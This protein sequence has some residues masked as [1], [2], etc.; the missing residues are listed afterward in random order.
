MVSGMRTGQAKCL[1]LSWRS[2][3]ARNAPDTPYDWNL[4]QC[5][6]TLRQHRAHFMNN[7]VRP[8]ERGLQLSVAAPR[9]ARSDSAG[10]AR[11]EADKWKMKFARKAA[12]L[13]ISAPTCESK[14]MSG[15]SS[16]MLLTST[17][18][19]TSASTTLA[20]HWRSRCTNIRSPNGMILNTDLRVNFL[21][22][23]YEIP[24]LI[25]RGRGVV[26][27]TS[28]SNAIAT[29]AKKSAYSTAKRGLVGMVQ[30][31][32]LPQRRR[33]LLAQNGRVYAPCATDLLRGD[34]QLFDQ[35]CVFFRI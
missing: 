16:I 5:P 1:S 13:V 27:V 11:N 34:V 35:L 12:S 19:L 14:T 18:A 25:Q 32:L 28:S 17:A 33:Q 10:G 24:H 22:L 23:K 2:F 29:T 21:S 3:L 9:A 26:V 31:A 4:G 8:Y 30:A 15:A 7:L 6:G 20:L